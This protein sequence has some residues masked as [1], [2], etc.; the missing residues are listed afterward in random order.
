MLF[1]FLFITEKLED[2]YAFSYNPQSEQLTR[3]AGWALFDIKSE[4][5]RMGLPNNEWC[6]SHINKD[7]K[8]RLSSICRQSGLS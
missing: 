2:L 6:C 7:Y 5:A 4:Y 8:V 1:Q 3:S